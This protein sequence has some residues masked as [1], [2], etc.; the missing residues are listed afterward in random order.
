MYTPNKGWEGWIS[1]F[2]QNTTSFIT[3]YHIVYMKISTDNCKV[4]YMP[5]STSH[6]NSFGQG[7]T[8]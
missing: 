1:F 8:I 3:M 7:F 4:D 6:F 2:E 5:T